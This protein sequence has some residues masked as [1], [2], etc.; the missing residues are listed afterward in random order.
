MPTVI[1]YDQ[2][3]LHGWIDISDRTGPLC[4]GD[5]IHY[6]YGAK[7]I[8]RIN[9]DYIWCEGD[10][11]LK[12]GKTIEYY[13]GQNMRTFRYIDSP[14]WGKSNRTVKR[15]QLPLNSHYSEPLPLP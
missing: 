11:A 8:I 1:P 14:Y 10:M 7:Q 2:A 9:T 13:A 6:A 3:V 5:T 12:S 15:K 4:P